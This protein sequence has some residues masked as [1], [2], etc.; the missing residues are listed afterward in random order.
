MKAGSE[1]VNIRCFGCLLAAKLLDAETF[2][3]S[4]G[5]SSVYWGNFLLSVRHFVSIAFQYKVADFCRLS[6]RRLFL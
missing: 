4:A 1:S 6:F 3:A 2:E 5:G